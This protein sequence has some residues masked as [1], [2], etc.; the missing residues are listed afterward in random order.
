MKKFVS[1]VLLISII[2]LA[3]GQFHE[4]IKK[5]NERNLKIPLLLKLNGLHQS[6]ISN[7]VLG[8]W[9]FKSPIEESNLVTT[10]RTNYDLKIGI[11]TKSRLNPEDSYRRY[12]QYYQDIE[13]EDGGVTLRCGPSGVQE[14]WSSLFDLKNLETNPM[15]LEIDL[16]Q[17]LNSSTISSKLMLSNNYSD[18]FSLIWKVFDYSKWITYLVDAYD[19]KIIGE[20][21]NGDGILAN[22]QYYGVQALNDRTIGPMTYLESPSQDIQV[23]E[24]GNGCIENFGVMPSTTQGLLWGA[25]DATEHCL[26]TFHV[27]SEIIPAYSTIGIDF[28]NVQCG[29]DPTIPNAFSWGAN[30]GCPNGAGVFPDA[31][32][33]SGTIQGSSFSTYDVL[34]H[35]LGHTYIRNF[36]D[37]G[38]FFF[39]S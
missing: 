30:T 25:N 37:S 23:F 28:Q 31:L 1:L 36:F 19:G 18:S 2:Q 16:S 15:I 9:K 33:T 12:N 24:T 4:S 17:I 20:F 27:L 39:G 5:N 21:S 11:S 32:L 26:Q 35:E 8:Y 6:D 13:V 29:C 7:N 14:I 38:F 10:L 3:H 34:G 22:T